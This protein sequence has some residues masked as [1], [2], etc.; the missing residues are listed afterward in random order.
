M[1]PLTDN[2]YRRN[3]TTKAR[4]MEPH[5]AYSHRIIASSRPLRLEPQRRLEEAANVFD[6]HEAFA[7]FCAHMTIAP[8]QTYRVTASVE[9]SADLRF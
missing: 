1:L 9:F 8:R 4:H 5:I 6:L 7:G 2:I 3:D